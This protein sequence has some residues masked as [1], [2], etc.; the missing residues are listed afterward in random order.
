MTWR[1]FH[2]RAKVDDFDVR[3]GV[4]VCSGELADSLPVPDGIVRDEIA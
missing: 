2:N 3:T 4:Q 1:G